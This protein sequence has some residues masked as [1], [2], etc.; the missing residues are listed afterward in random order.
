[1]NQS[2]IQILLTARN[3]AQQAFAEFSKSITDITAGLLKTA[4]ASTAAGQAQTNAGAASRASAQAHRETASAVHENAQA[5]EGLTEVLGPFVSKYL[6]ARTIF[7]VARN[8]YKDYTEFIRS[9]VEAYA[10]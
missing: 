10:E 6:E 7:E 8:A 9:S 5:H 4:E 1:M 2:E 3:Q